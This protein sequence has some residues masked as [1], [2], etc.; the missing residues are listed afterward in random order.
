MTYS[1]YLRITSAGTEALFTRHNLLDSRYSVK[2]EILLAKDEYMWMIAHFFRFEQ[3]FRMMRN[4]QYHYPMLGKTSTEINEVKCLQQRLDDSTAKNI[5]GSKFLPVLSKL[6]D[7]RFKFIR[8][9][10]ENP[11]TMSLKKGIHYSLKTTKSRLVCGGIGVTWPGSD[12]DVELFVHGCG[13]C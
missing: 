8:F 10:H 11:G 1:Y 12:K 5:F 13:L 3:L 9:A 4:S 2:T 6:D 7:F